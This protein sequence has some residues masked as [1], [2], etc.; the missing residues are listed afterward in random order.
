[1]TA[2][3]HAVL[4][5]IRQLGLP[6]RDLNG[7]RQEGFMRAQITTLHGSRFSPDRAYLRGD[8]DN[9][10]IVTNALVDKVR[11]VQSPCALLPDEEN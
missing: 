8:Q 2:L 5:G 7:A 6:V 1:L 4:K 9:L 10:R 11:S 3:G